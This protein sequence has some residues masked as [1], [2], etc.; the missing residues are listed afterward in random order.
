MEAVTKCLQGRMTT[1]CQCPTSNPALLS[2]RGSDEFP[3]KRPNDPKSG[4]ETRGR[5]PVQMTDAGSVPR[6][7]TKNEAPTVLGWG[8]SCLIAPPVPACS[9]RGSW[10]S[11][12]AAPV[13]LPAR[14]GPHSTL[15]WPFLTP[16]SLPGTGLKSAKAIR[17]Q[18]HTDQ[19]VTR[20]RIKQWDRSLGWQRETLSLCFVGGYRLHGETS[21]NGPPSTRGSVS[22]LQDVH[23]LQLTALLLISSAGNRSPS[24]RRVDGAYM[25]RGF[26]LVVKF[27][28]VVV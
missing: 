28:D 17:N 18:H 11:L 27:Q 6:S 9:Y 19:R 10:G 14:S 25:F 13:S 20:G 5:T 15:S 24:P 3:R 16:T 26:C 21:M 8:F 7:T 2:F 1:G 23:R 22:A 4:P 12:R